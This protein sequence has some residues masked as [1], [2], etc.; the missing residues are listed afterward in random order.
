M[1]AKMT[2]SNENTD[3]QMAMVK[4]PEEVAPFETESTTEGFEGAVLGTISSLF[5]GFVGEDPIDVVVEL[6]G[7]LAVSTGQRG[8]GGSQ[9]VELVCERHIAAIG[10]E[11]LRKLGSSGRVPLNPVSFNCKSFKLRRLEREL[12]SPHILG[13]PFKFSFSRDLN[14]ANS[15]GSLPTKLFSDKSSSR[16]ES[17][18]VITPGNSFP[19]KLRRAIC[20]YIKSMNRKQTKSKQ[21]ISIGK[22]LINYLAR[23]YV[24]HHLGFDSEY[25]N[26]QIL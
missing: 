14:R 24:R 4:N 11:Q 20:L 2:P 26:V 22:T 6:F 18:E 10:T 9:A 16:R 12:N 3:A 5:E 19:S 8:K 1:A 21:W 7:K 13:F 17:S 25:G 23:R 15:L